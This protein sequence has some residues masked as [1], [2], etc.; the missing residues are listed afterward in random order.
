MPN[1]IVW[2]PDCQDFHEIEA[3]AVVPNRRIGPRPLAPDPL[4]FLAEKLAYD[5]QWIEGV[6]IE[7]V[8]STTLRLKI[9]HSYPKGI[10]I[11]PIVRQWLKAHLAPNVKAKTIYQRVEPVKRER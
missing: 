1:F 10:V 5:F 4:D 9:K 2:C 6:S 8:G 3:H 7:V 11:A